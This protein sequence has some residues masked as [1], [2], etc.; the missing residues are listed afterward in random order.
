AITGTVLRRSYQTVYKRIVSFRSGTALTA[1]CGKHNDPC[2]HVQLKGHAIINAETCVT[3]YMVTDSIV[4]GNI[5]KN[6]S[7]I[8]DGGWYIISSGNNALVLDNICLNTGQGNG[9]AAGAVQLTAFTHVEGNRF[10]GAFNQVWDTSGRG[11]TLI[12]GD[13]SIP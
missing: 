7:F 4:K 12:Y 5:I 9:A 11:D 10:Q 8:A 2:W 13:M 6:A 3:I 1:F